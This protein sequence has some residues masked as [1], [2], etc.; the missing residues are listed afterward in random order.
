VRIVCV[1]QVFSSSTFEELQQAAFR[2]TIRARRT[3]PSAVPSTSSMSFITR[4]LTNIYLFI[5]KKNDK[6]RL[7]P[8][9]CHTVSNIKITQ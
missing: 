2:R 8:L 7:A 1:V 6:R 4:T 9:T 5:Y 3:P